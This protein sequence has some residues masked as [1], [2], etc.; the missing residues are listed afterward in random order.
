MTEARSTARLHY[1]ALVPAAF[2][3]AMSLVSAGPG[4][5]Q[6][7]G[8]APVLFIDVSAGLSYE[9]NLN[10]DG[11]FEATTGID[12]GYF[13]STHNQRLTFQTGVTA[14]AL[15]NRHDLIDPYLLVSYAR[16]NRDFEISGELSYVRSEI[17]GDDLD[18]DFDAGDLARQVGRREGIGFGL[19]LVTG[20]TAPFGTDTE[21]RYAQETFSD[22]ATD[23]DST[24]H[25]ARSTLRF[26]IDPRIELSLTGFWEQEE[27]DDV[28]NTV[29]TTRRLTF[30]TELA[31]DRA[32]SA[33]ASIGYADIETET[34][35]G[36]VSTDGIEGSLILTRDLPNG[37][38]AFSMDHVLDTDGWRNS[39]RVRRTIEMANGDLFDASIG[40][41]FFEE[42]GSGHLA[43]LDY[44]RNT[45]TGVL[46]FGVDYSSDLDPTDQLV[47]RTRLNALMRQDITDDSGWSLDGALARV[48]H[49]NPA[50]V[51][52]MRIDV[53]LAYLRALSNDWNLA[54]RVEH[55]ILYQD[56][57]LADR[58]NVLSLNLE[59]R[60]SVRP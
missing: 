45:R 36:T 57:G 42:G 35:G 32:W 50:A 33:S 1:K 41:V 58:T 48:D 55:Q 51:D 6:E 43:S 40:Q 5:A 14:R 13:S 52:A 16:F 8:E 10:R 49:D 3:S 24:T 11:E 20:R 44:T 22:G 9:D 31:I 56:G 19:R 18:A 4:A 34:L 23:E 7:G 15:E 21:L 53:G 38:L 27:T 26:S 59:R 25:T 29:E 39:I 47:Q 46:S 12:V 30:G 37:G 2:A 60:F 28:A 17:E 54:V